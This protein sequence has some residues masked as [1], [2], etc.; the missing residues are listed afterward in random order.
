MRPI[1]LSYRSLE[2]D[3]A[4]RIAADLKNAGIALWMD[5]LD[6]RPGDDWMLA[7]ERAVN[8]CA[9]MIVVLSPDYVVSEHCRRELQRAA[10]LK[11][12]IFPLL[13][14]P[15]TEPDVP[16]EIEGKQHIDFTDWRDDER[17]REQLD[18]L[19]TIL[20]TETNAH[21]SA[22]PDT[23]TRYLISLI[24]EI[25]ARKE[26][27]QYVDLSDASGSLPLANPRLVQ[28]SVLTG[29]VEVVRDG[30]LQDR[31]LPDVREAV[32]RFPRFVLIGAAGMG[33]STALRHLALEAARNRLESPRIAP[34]PLLL[35]LSEWGEGQTLQAFIRTHWKLDGDPVDL[36]ARGRAVIYLDGLNEMGKFTPDRVAQLR[37]WL[38]GSE[39]PRHVIF[40]CRSGDYNAL[41]DLHL[42]VVQ[43]T[44]LNRARIRDY[45]ITCLDETT[46]A[47]LLNRI[48]GVP[49][50]DAHPLYQLA[51]YPFL[52]N[53]L[54][55][56]YASGG[57][58]PDNMGALLERLVG[59]WWQK[60]ARRRDLSSGQ[61]A[62]LKAG[63]NDLAF[64]MIH[65]EMPIYVP[66][67]DAI[68]YV[69]S[70]DLIEIACA[71]NFLEQAGD[72][73]RFTHQLMLEYFAAHGLARVELAAR[74]RKPQL[75]DLGQRIPQKWD[76]VVITLAGMG[77]TNPEEVT[78]AVL[79]IDPYLALECIASG[80]DVSNTL[81]RQAVNRVLA[82]LID[83]YHESRL[84]AVNALA[85]IG[86]EQAVTILLD[87][88]RIGRWANRMAALDALE[89][90]RITPLPG[91]TDALSGLSDDLRESTA[92][93][94]R[95]IGEDAIPTLLQLLGS[96]QWEMRRNA[97]WALGVVGDGAAAPGLVRALG[98]VQNAVIAEAVSSLGW[99]RDEATV[100]MMMGALKHE[101]WRVRKAAAG[102]LG[103]MGKAA[104]DGL[105]IVLESDPSPKQRRLAVEAVANIRDSAV[106][107]VLLKASRDASA[108]VRAVA[109]EALAE[110]PGPVV[111]KRLIESL[112]DVERPR[113][114]KL[115]ICDLAAQ[116][117]EKVDEEEV[118]QALDRW[119][120]GLS[121]VKMLRRRLDLYVVRLPLLLRDLRR[122]HARV[123]VL[124]RLPGKRFQVLLVLPQPNIPLNIVPPG[125]IH[126]TGRH[127]IIAQLLSALHQIDENGAG[128]QDA[129]KALREYAKALRGKG[130]LSAIHQLVSALDDSKWQV[131]WTVA[132]ALAWAAD[133]AAVPALIRRLEDTNWNVQIASIRALVEIGDRSVVEPLAALLDSKHDMV[134]EVAAEALGSLG[135][136]A[137]VPRLVA[138]LR[139]HESFVQQ[140]AIQALGRVRDNGA[141]AALTPLLRHENDNV[142][143]LV[144][145]TLG[146]IGDRRAVPF[147]TERLRDTCQPHLQATRICDEAV[148]ALRAIG[149]PDA[150]AAVEG[151]DR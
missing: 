92:V 103:W 123:Y 122:K 89:R 4:L 46:A 102:A 26:S 57:G 1:F 41:L 72:S 70:R 38:N 40:T 47:P 64:A 90:V 82:T 3:F 125:G 61:L 110:L 15:V 59:M 2:T 19:V 105:R 9:A 135:S 65:Q 76:G 83:E 94:L 112:N 44:R 111:T 43:M 8:D 58:L 141:V 86:H 31:V 139:D 66:V 144:T 149:T 28:G 87:A 136:R 75:N 140:A 27:L 151:W 78:R 109:L 42:P 30:A 108:E 17:Y 107:P 7:L 104:I 13:L 127:K 150:L 120:Q 114:R 101:N 138:A 68:E 21:S 121:P 53:L 25:E 62:E 132:E 34:L 36:L 11:R 67:E 71:A 146:Q 115:R 18:L 77:E 133:A 98:D 35:R 106:L 74:L 52:L 23:E 12:P 96:P 84:A 128:W 55:Q 131:R 79:D 95:K 49:T 148:Q 33:K 60:E 142:R 137:A 118:R 24:A 63:L 54:V 124:S 5:R 14:R 50:D 97:A 73:I 81:R 39:S 80:I 119:R 20:K 51:T 134:R 10:R 113:W 85:A 116:L 16:M 91:V 130:D 88:L 143:W 48:L 32:E 56:M 99:L 145:R 29:A 45:I 6:I 100:S 129:S 126:E 22:L 117:L 37:A 93:A 147:L 69:G